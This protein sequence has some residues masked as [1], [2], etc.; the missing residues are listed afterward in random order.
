MADCRA[1]AGPGKG[2]GGKGE[3]SE[4]VCRKCYRWGHRAR[5]CRTVMALAENGPC[6]AEENPVQMVDPVRVPVPE[7]DPCEVPVPDDWPEIREVERRAHPQQS[8]SARGGCTARGFETVMGERG[9]IR[10][11][12]WEVPLKR[13]GAMYYL[14]VQM[15]TDA[16]K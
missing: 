11:G 6:P 8:M 14:P 3:A 7:D 16:T 4:G 15:Y 9:F 10:K 5:D 13:S 1:T 12:D 2:K